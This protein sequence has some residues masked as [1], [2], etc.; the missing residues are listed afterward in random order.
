MQ[1]VRQ[2]IG[3]RLLSSMAAALDAA[4]HRTRSVAATRFTDE[5]CARDAIE[6]ERASVEVRVVL[7]S[8]H[9]CSS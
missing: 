6:G 5:D 2:V 9:R 7:P 1:P 3:I 4:V 8:A